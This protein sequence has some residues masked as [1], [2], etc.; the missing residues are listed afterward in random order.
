[1]SGEPVE[2]CMN[3]LNGEKT[4]IYGD[5]RAA[6]HRDELSL[7]RKAVIASFDADDARCSDQ[8]LHLED[9]KFRDILTELNGTFSLIL[10]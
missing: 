4:R 3:E 6:G 5:R 1:M 10:S 8:L 2:C 7:W 9:S